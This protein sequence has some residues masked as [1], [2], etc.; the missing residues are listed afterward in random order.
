MLCQAVPWGDCLFLRDTVQVQ[1][2]G[3]AVLG[4]LAPKGR[5]TSDAAQHSHDVLAR[6]LKRLALYTLDRHALRGGARPS[7]WPCGDEFSCAYSS[8]RSWLFRN[9]GRWL[10]KPLLGA[11]RYSRP[12]PAA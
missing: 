7:C 2:P 6:V 1:S 11:N 3:A 10:L 8:C 4:G 12:W 5:A 9:L